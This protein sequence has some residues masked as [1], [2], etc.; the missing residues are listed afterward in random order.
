[1]YKKGANERMRIV[2]KRNLNRIKAEYEH[3][4]G[5]TVNSLNLEAFKCITFP[6][7]FSLLTSEI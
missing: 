5:F 1:M 6:H 4:F 7:L 3:G 2:S